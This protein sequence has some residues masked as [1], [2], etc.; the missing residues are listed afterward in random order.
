MVFVT[1]QRFPVEIL[2]ALYNSVTRG[3]LKHRIENKGGMNG[4]IVV[5]MSKLRRIDTSEFFHKME[6]N[7]RVIIAF[8]YWTLFFG[9][10]Q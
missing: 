4:L 8:R 10:G 7:D 6:G 5:D 1:G 9:T 3:P 2:F